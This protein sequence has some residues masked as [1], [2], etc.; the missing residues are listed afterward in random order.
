MSFG[1]SNQ[2]KRSRRP[3]QVEE[4]DETEQN[5]ARTDE[6]RNQMIPTVITIVGSIA[7]VGILLMGAPYSYGSQRIHYSGGN[8]TKAKELLQL[9][10]KERAEAD[11]KLLMDFTTIIVPPARAT[12]EA[13]KVV[14]QKCRQGRAASLVAITPDKTHAAFAKA[15]KYLKCAMATKPE[16]FCLADERKLLVQ[17]LMDYKERRQNALAF[18]QH[19]EKVLVAHESFRDLKRQ[20]GGKIPPPL[21]ISMETVDETIDAGLLFNLERL[22]SN[23][24]ITA[25]DFGYYG[26][27][28]PSEFQS[29]L[30]GGADRYAACATR[31]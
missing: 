20:Q 3:K 5:E 21:D 23:G 1:K 11:P 31:T 13:M 6:Q 16:R 28:V 4:V 7:M 2:P 10:K 12:T 15:T 27:Y 22:V 29:A 26:F 30:S 24:Y 17:Q 8:I 18:E 19:R 25:K 9:D 14:A